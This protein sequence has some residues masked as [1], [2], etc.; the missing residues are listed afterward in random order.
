MGTRV[1][2]SCDVRMVCSVT[3]TVVGVGETSLFDIGM[4]GLGEV[5]EFTVLPIEVEAT[6]EDGRGGRV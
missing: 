2:H 3:L 6:C 5:G 4:V 1:T